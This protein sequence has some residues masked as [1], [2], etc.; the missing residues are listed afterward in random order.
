M[1]L[2]AD[3]DVTSQRALCLSSDTGTR[4]VN[5]KMACGA[6]QTKIADP[7]TNLTLGTRYN[8]VGEKVSLT[9]NTQ[10]RRVQ[11]QSEA[12]NCNFRNLS[13]LCLDRGYMNYDVISTARKVGLH[14]AG[15]LKRCKQNPF[16]FGGSKEIDGVKRIEEYRV[17]ADY[18]QR[19]SGQMVH[20]LFIWRLQKLARCQGEW[21]P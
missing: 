12:L 21:K 20:A 1:S 3:D 8:S 11:G 17:L 9:I 5:L 10:F 19:K 15:T 13:T 14:M 18:W 2:S 16:T 6:Q 4:Q 7:L